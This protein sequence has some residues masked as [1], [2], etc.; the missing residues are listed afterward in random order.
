MIGRRTG[1][2]AGR[3][4]AVLTAGGNRPKT[5]LAFGHWK[6]GLKPAVW[7]MGA[8]RAERLT[9]GCASGDGETPAAG[10]PQTLGREGPPPPGRTHE[11]HGAAPKPGRHT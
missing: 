9:R 3:W 11:V 1:G 2:P 6:L 8:V 7:T 10:S 5:A 4:W